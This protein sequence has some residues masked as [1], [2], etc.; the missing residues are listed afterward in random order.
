MLA[1][2]SH[3]ITHTVA[4]QQLV[5]RHKIGLTSKTEGG[6][7]IAPPNLVMSPREL[8]IESESK[9]DVEDSAMSDQSSVRSSPKRKF[10]ELLSA[11]QASVELPPPPPPPLPPAI[12][13]S[14]LPPTQFTGLTPVRSLTDESKVYVP[15]P[16]PPPFGTPAPLGAVPFGKLEVP[17]PMPDTV[18]P[19]QPPKDGVLVDNCVYA[20]HS[21]SDVLCSFSDSS[22]DRDT[23]RDRKSP[24]G[25]R[26]VVRIDVLQSFLERSKGRF[27]YLEVFKLRST[28]NPLK[29]KVTFD[30]CDK[31][32][33]VLLLAVSLHN[34][35]ESHLPK[36]G[37][38]NERRLVRVD[39]LQSFLERSKTD[40]SDISSFGQLRIL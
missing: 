14:A 5:R 30:R 37:S 20:V 26:R 13:M 11:S 10:S 21:L 28:P 2:L 39:I 29:H 19:P 23:S 24:S 36:H 31:L 27:R 16:P 17:C 6:S 1:D 32:F 33:Y 9:Y 18:L 22:D 12:A 40:V 4:T 25:E 38:P 7:P 15:P 8:K 34:K 35:Q 3:R